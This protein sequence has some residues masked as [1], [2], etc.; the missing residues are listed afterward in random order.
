MSA[1]CPGDHS[2][3][4]AISARSTSFRKVGF[5]IRAF[6]WSYS[7]LS[8]RLNVA[9]SIRGSDGVGLRLYADRPDVGSL[10]GV[11]QPSHM[12]AS[13]PMEPAQ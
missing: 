13:W 3:K 4:T 9:P 5:V 11:V 10:L 12:L 7:G 1:C 8:R 2:T 6:R